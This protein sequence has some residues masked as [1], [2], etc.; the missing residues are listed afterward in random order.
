MAASIPTDHDPALPGDD[1]QRGPTL[2]ET[3]PALVSQLVQLG[4][5]Y[6]IAGVA[7]AARQLLARGKNV[8]HRVPSDP[9]PCTCT[10]GGL[11][12]DADCPRHADIVKAS[13]LRER[14]MAA[15]AEPETILASPN[16]DWFC[17][18]AKG[19]IGGGGQRRQDYGDALDSFEAIAKLWSVVLGVDVT[20][21]QVA[22]CQA[23]LKMG[24]LLNT[25]NHEDSWVDIIGYAALGGDIAMRPGRNGNR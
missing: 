3:S 24:R 16:T 23:M 12:W 22:L 4:D 6:G 11:T 7:R 1:D 17:D 10:P 20:A 15:A 25:P 9:R 14:R 2:E 5:Q 21:E 13:V 18:R 19:I 8:S